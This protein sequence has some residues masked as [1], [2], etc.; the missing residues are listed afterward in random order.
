MASIQF[1]FNNVNTS[2]QVGD[3]AY[4]ASYGGQAEFSV[5]SPSITPIGFVSSI[6]VAPTT[7]MNNNDVTTGYLVTCTIEDNIELT[8]PANV[9]IFFS[10]DNVANMSSILGY[11]GEVEFKNNSFEKAE[12]FAASCEMSESSK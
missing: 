12:L 9:F 8:V 1:T 5:A 7:D 3:T 11:Y 6:A 4:Y 10:K 2:L